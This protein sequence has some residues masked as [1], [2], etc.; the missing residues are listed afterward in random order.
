MVSL[1]M[2]HLATAHFFFFISVLGEAFTVDEECLVV[3]V[4]EGGPPPFE[5]LT[6]FPP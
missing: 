3:V 2:V 5:A 4:H 6:N 1:M